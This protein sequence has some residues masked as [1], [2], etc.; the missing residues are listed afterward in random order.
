[1]DRGGRAR[2][3]DER[4]FL[5]LG[6]LGVDVAGR[7]LRDVTLSRVGGHDMGRLQ[8]FARPNPSHDLGLDQRNFR[9]LEDLIRGAVQ[10][11]EQDCRVDAASVVLKVDDLPRSVAVLAAGGVTDS[12]FL[13]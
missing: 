7:V 8:L 1:L 12:D 11:A 6:C 10:K 13:E 5:H 9:A 2:T 4:S 3:I